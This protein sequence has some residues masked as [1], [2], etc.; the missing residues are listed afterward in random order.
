MQ[1]IDSANE[2]KDRATDWL[3]HGTDYLENRWNLSVLEASEK[4]AGVVSSLAAALIIGLMGAI[5]LLFVSLGAAWL[6]GER[7][8]SPSAGYFIVALFYA[9]VGGI[10]YAVRDQYIKVPVINSFIK[11][12]YY[13]S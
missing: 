6:I 12:F 3:D 2:I 8:D 13:E 9:I 7:L 5:T 10:L 11:R 1:I 4:T